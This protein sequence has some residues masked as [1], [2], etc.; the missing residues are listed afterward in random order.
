MN[1]S[2]QLCCP[3]SNKNEINTTEKEKLKEMIGK[4][5]KKIY[6]PEQEYSILSIFQGPVQD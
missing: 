5:Q 4:K 3:A 1:P 2:Q 6:L